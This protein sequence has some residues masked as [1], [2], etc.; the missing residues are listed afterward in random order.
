MRL[1]S[2]LLT[3]RPGILIL[4]KIALSSSRNCPGTM[5]I[6]RLTRRLARRS[7]IRVAFISE[8]KLQACFRAQ[9]AN[10][11]YKVASLISR[12][13]PEL[14][15]RLPRKRKPWETEYRNM[16][17]FDAAALGMTYLTSGIDAVRTRR[18]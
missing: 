18:G 11:K 7:S 1:A 10:T 9:G 5:T 3:I 8:R 14:A 2:L 17:I 12:E 6:Q 4:R 13:Y 15:W 16:S